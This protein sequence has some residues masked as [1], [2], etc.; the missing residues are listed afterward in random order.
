MTQQ[1][2]RTLPD[3]ELNEI[4]DIVRQDDF[5]LEPKSQVRLF[6]SNLVR[7][8]F[9]A[10]FAR[11]GNKLVALKANAYGRLKVT[12]RQDWTFVNCYSISAATGSYT[13]L[14]IGMGATWK[15]ITLTVLSAD[16]I[17][18]ITFDGPAYTFYQAYAVGPLVLEGPIST[19]DAQGVTG[20]SR[21]SAYVLELAAES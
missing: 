4:K 17:W 2:E 8:A 10:L 21:C 12:T 3:E 18:R 11:V 13:S 19:I 6:L 14:L 1:P 5:R 16:V 9:S 7:W 20:T 15:R